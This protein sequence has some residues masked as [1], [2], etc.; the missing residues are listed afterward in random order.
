MKLKIVF[1]ALLIIYFIAMLYLATTPQALG[2]SG[3]DL[4]DKWLHFI[5][6]FVFG[7]LLYIT[8]E[9]YEFHDL[10]LIYMI[11]ILGVVLLSELVQIPIAGRAFSVKDMI[12]DMAGALTALV[13]AEGVRLAWKLLKR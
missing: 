1:T 13:F 11:V 9:F 3:I 6:F 2:V 4:S 8:L 5:E 7:I 12:A 10:Y